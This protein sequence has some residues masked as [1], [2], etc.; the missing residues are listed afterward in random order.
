MLWKISARRKG[1]DVDW[2]QVG[3]RLM[4][5]VCVASHHQRRLSQR[6]NGRRSWVRSR[7]GKKTWTNW[8]WTSWLLRAMLRLL[9]SSRWSQELNVSLFIFGNGLANLLCIPEPDIPRRSSGLFKKIP[10]SCVLYLLWHNWREE[11]WYFVHFLDVA[12]SERLWHHLFN[13]NYSWYGGGK[14]AYSLFPERLIADIDLGTIT[15]RMAVRKAVQCGQVEDAI[16]K[17]ND[18]NPEVCFCSHLSLMWHAV[19]ITVSRLTSQ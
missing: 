2:W 7:S 3:T 19:S 17:V 16:E 15:D 1:N 12:F 11:W 8:W 6:K 10:M 14:K 9:R 13:H 5:L 4:F 18:L